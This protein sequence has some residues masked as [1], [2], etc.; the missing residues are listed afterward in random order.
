MSDRLDGTVAIV[1]GASSGIGHATALTLASRGAT[2]V[3]VARRRDRLDA[4]VTT[5]ESAGGRALAIDADVSSEAD[6]TAV[7]TRTIAALRRLDTLVNAAGVMLIG[8][9][10]SSPTEHWNRMVDVNLKGVMYLTKAALPYLIDGVTSSDRGVTD[11]VTIS[12][13]AGRVANPYAAI[14]NATKFAVTAASEAWR[15]E[16][17]TRGVRFSAIEPGAVSTEIANEQEFSRAWY[18]EQAALGDVLLADDIAEAVSYIVSNH[19]RIAVGE[20]VIRPTHQ[21]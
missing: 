12:S 2:V 18:A 19:R 10:V 21:A 7:V 6:A 5:I 4:L 14:Y 16:Y 9:S 11:V 1:T 8:D 20:I 17:A 13:T 3:A 15:Q